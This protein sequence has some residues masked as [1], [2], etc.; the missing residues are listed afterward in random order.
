[1]ERYQISGVPITDDDGRLVGIL[2]NRDLRFEDATST[3]PVGDADDRARTSSPCPVGTTLEEAEA[4]LH[5]H[6]IEK[7]PVV[8]ADGDLKGLI[9]VKDIQKRI[10]YP[11]AT[12]DELRAPARRRGR[13]RRRRC[14]R[15]RRALVDAE[16]DV[17]VVDTAHG[18]SPRRAR[19]GARR[20]RSASPT[21]QLIA[22]NI[23]TR[24]GGARADRARCRR[25]QGRHR[26]GIDLHDARRRRRRRAADHRRS[27]TCAQAAAGQRHPGHRRRRHAVLGRHREGDRRRRRRGDDRVAARRGRTR[28]RA[29][30]SLPGRALQGVSRHGLARRDEGTAARKDRYFQG[31]VEDVDKLVPEGIEGRVPYKGPLAVD[32]PPVRRRPAPGD[33]LLRRG[34]DHST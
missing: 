13:G 4:I 3:Q 6:R 14:D 24:R 2:T 18:H 33:G 1:M 17:L 21:S 10:Q 11:D 19:R 7:L 25:G 15:A 28:P 34:R 23:A 9:T 31:D 32:R 16:V 27:T 8:D 26:T 29:R 20:S 22:G 30:S 12:K 5:R